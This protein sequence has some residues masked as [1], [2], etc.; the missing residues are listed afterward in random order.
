MKAII[1]IIL[2]AALAFGGWKFYEFYQKYKTDQDLK[3]QQD[4][5]VTQVDPAQ[6]AGMPQ[7]WESQYKNSTNSGIKTWA[8]WMKLYAQRVGDPR[9]AWIELDYMVR[10]SSDDP[11][12]AKQIYSM[13]KDRITDTNSPVYPRLNQLSRT[14]E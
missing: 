2:V 12:E 10:I 4:A 9:R 6:L 8:A 1:S 7:Q 5:A 13:V 11:Q 14:Y 3:E